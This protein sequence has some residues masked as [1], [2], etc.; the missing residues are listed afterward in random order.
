MKQINAATIGMAGLI[1]SVIITVAL[2]IF[3][4][5]GCEGGGADNTGGN[6]SYNED[7]YV[8]GEDSN[9]ELKT[10]LVIATAPN[11]FVGD[12]YF[13][14][15]LECEA[16]SSCKA[17]VEGTIQIEFKRTDALFLTKY[18][19]VGS[20]KEQTVTW[21]EPGDWGLAPNGMY[22]SDESNDNVEV[23]TIMEDGNILLRKKGYML[24]EVYGNKF[25]YTAEGGTEY[26]GIITAD[27]KTISYHRATP[28]GNEFDFVLTLVE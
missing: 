25:S 3:V 7:G 26:N 1:L 12:F 14:E 22:F 17:E 23:E 21:D 16:S 9:G 27:L 2:S 11:D 18:V 20:D 4:L 6:Y 19:A 8:N 15:N 5:A 28:G 10:G 24:G 13:D